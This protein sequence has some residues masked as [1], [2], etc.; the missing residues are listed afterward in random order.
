[1]NNFHSV[2]LPANSGNSVSAS[3][4]VLTVKRVSGDGVTVAMNGF[5]PLPILSGSVLNG[6]F[7]S[8][9]FFNTG[10]ATVTVE[11]FAGDTAVAFAPRDSSATN[12]RSYLYGNLGIATAGVANVNAPSQTPLPTCD[13][14]GFLQI[15]NGMRL[16][17]PGI[18]NGA[19][20]QILVLSVDPLAAFALNVIDPTSGAAT[21]P[22]AEFAGITLKAG[23]QIELLTD[24]DIVLSGAGGTVGVTV[25]QIFLSNT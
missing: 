13:A 12:A 21:S 20:R 11:F 3:G 24:S 10:T 14:N 7:G 5:S 6:K 8:L 1:M 2:T 23:A 9:N 22:T 18:R 25:G 16:L 4:K 19:R 15:T 17:V